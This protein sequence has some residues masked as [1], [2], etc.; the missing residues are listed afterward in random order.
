D[1]EW[2]QTCYYKAQAD[3]KKASSLAILAQDN[4]NKL[5]NI[6]IEE[7]ECLEEATSVWEI[8]A[9]KVEDLSYSLS[10]QRP[11]GGW[12]IRKV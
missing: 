7:R 5:W 8:A 11:R 6:M 1:L 10:G 9:K 3:W 2:R 12:G 4:A